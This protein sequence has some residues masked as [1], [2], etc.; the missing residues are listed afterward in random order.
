MDWGLVLVSQGIEATI[1][2]SEDGTSWGLMVARP[3]LGRALRA[4]RLYRLENRGWPWQQQVLER[5]YLFDW[6][7]LAWVL[8]V[9]LFYG[10][11][12]RAELRPA[13][14]LVGSLVTH[15]QWWRLFTAIWLHGDVGHLASNATFGFV[16]LGLA[17]GRYGT[18]AGLLAAYLG[19]V[20]GNVVSWLVS[21]ELHRSLGA[22]GMVM[23]GLG[24]LAAQSLSARPRPAPAR[25]V[26]LAGIFS[27]VMLF[28]LLGL[29]PGTDVLAHLGGFLSGLLLGG[30]LGMLPVMAQKAGV[31][32]G[33]GLLFTV[34]VVLPWR[35]ALR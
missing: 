27:G 14:A 32:L 5:G 11:D 3:E 9:I 18:G 15:G 10:L 4:L 12:A 20:G 19:G 2:C 23:A 30:L 35:L 24:L 26:V 1:D 22:S 34:L 21:G 8:L 31:N 13:G 28:T 7:S 17:M 6:G 33:C 29:T 16:L 25:K